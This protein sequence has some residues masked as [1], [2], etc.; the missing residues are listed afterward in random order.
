MLDRRTFLISAAATLLSANEALAFHRGSSHRKKKKQSS[1]RRGTR[2][3]QPFNL[4]AKYEPQRIVY[5]G[6]IY[7]AGSIVID[8]ENRFLY[9]IEDAETATRFGVGVDRAGLSIRGT[10]Y[11][12]RKSKWPSWT[13]TPNMIRNEP[14]YARYAGGMRG[15][16]G[17]PLGARALYLYRGN[18]DTLYRIHGTNQ[19]RS[20]GQAMSS[21]CI[22]ML[23]AHAEVLYEKVSVPA[24]VVILTPA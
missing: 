24:L 18:Q 20:I 3:Q 22:R 16:V 12:K 14:R 7:P 2:P 11:V 17:N 10:A 9:F 1:T 19:P 5:G 23:N 6:G 4:D 13:P 21:G 15:G 8:P